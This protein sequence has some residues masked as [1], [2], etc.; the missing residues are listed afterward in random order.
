MIFL[1]DASVYVF[2][3]YHSQLPEMVDRDG[4][5]V[6]AVFGFARFLGDLMERI[7]PR[8]VGVAFDQRLTTSYR[9]RIYPAYKAHREPAPPGIARQFEYCRELCRH[10][11]L[12]AFVDPEFEADDIIG[13]L[14]CLMRAEGIRSAFIT[15]DKD[16]AQLVRDGDLLWD[17]GARTQLGYR[18]VQRRFG[19]APEGF[20]DYLALT[21][22]A[23]DN[24]P[25][26]PGVGPKI[27]ATLLRKFGSL[28]ELYANIGRVAALGL[29]GGSALGERLAAHRDSVFLARRLTRIVCDMP[30][31]VTAS[32]LR[33]GTPDLAALGQLYDRLGFGPLLRRQ[34]ERLAEQRW[35]DAAAVA[36]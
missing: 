33:P 28:D 5:P 19:V 35:A 12:A 10:L 25:G 18:D 3:A 1:I 17:F 8:Y 13:T 31:G 11:G 20:A 34:S 6:H 4:N 36:S 9:N 24:I 32:H 23:S 27:A 7:R 22:D 2:R 26:V 21:G 16:L 29:R 30:L 15:R 14:S